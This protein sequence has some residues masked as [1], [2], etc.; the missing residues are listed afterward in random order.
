[1]AA[2]EESQQSV[3]EM[4][5]LT[6]GTSVQALL[7]TLHAAPACSW[8]VRRAFAATVQRIAHDPALQSLGKDGKFQLFVLLAIRF[9]F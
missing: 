8:L 5:P 4:P 2:H 9:V 3:S 7:A 1:M 6:A